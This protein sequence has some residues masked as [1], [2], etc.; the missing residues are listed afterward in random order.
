MGIAHLDDARAREFEIGHIRGR[1]TDLGSASGSVGI[2]LARIQVPAGGWSTPAHEHGAEEEIFYVL[3]GRGLAW[4]NGESAEIGPGDCIVYLPGHGAHTVHALEPLDLL[5]FGPRIEIEVTGLPRLGMT[6]VANRAVDSVPGRIDGAPIQFVREAELGPP[7]LPAAPGARPSTIVNVNAVEP[8]RVAR[9]QVAR[10]RRNLGVAAGSVTTGL[11]HVEVD[12]GKESA[13]LHCHS[14]EH[15][16]FVI[17]HGDGVLVLDD[18]VETPVRGGHVVSRPAGTGIAHL[19]RAGSSGLTYLAYGTREPGDNCFYPR[20]NK[21]AFR[22]L[23]VIARVER[24]DYW[25]GEE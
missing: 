24:L 20:S 19:F 15:E 22:G 16:L 9:S 2:G 3:A 18:E 14:L 11:Q 21:I 8:S 23:N 4:Q 10:T 17:L 12:P 25:D 1:W 13:P 7:E 6:R 5:A